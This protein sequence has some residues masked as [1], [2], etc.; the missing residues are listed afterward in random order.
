MAFIGNIVGRLG[1]DPEMR[2]TKTGTPMCTFNVADNRRYTDAEGNQVESTIWVTCTAFGARAES[3]K[4]YLKRGQ[5]VYAEGPITVRDFVR[6]DGSP[7][8]SIN[9]RVNEMQFLQS[10]DP[11]GE[12]DEH[13]S[14]I[15]TATVEPDS[16][17][18]V[19]ENDP[20]L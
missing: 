9:V 3:A 1:Q 10:R 18:D 12:D 2:T 17:W 8:Y 13:D 4:N 7:G 16:G 5:L 6:A 15:E 20:D 11:A 14:D 19:E